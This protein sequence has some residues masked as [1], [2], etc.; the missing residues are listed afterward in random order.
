MNFSERRFVNV[1]GVGFIK[2]PLEERVV[3]RE[4]GERVA[5]GS[6]LRGS[7]AMCTQAVSKSS[8]G[9]EAQEERPRTN[10]AAHHCLGGICGG[11]VV[12]RGVGRGRRRRWGRRSGARDACCGR[13]TRGTQS[14]GGGH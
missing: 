11:L 12:M 2:E 3:S 4:A 8:R 13:H 10:N 5:G 6:G 7:N 1:G 14:S 9:N